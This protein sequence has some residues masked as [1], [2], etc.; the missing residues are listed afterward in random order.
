MEYEVWNKSNFASIVI[1]E[2]AARILKNNDSFGPQTRS[3]VGELK[4]HLAYLFN[5]DVIS[6]TI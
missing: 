4:R 5:L 1:N 2:M 6:T 3:W